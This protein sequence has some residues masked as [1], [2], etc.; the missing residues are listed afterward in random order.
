[1]VIAAGIV[2]LLL[3]VIAVLWWALKKDPPLPEH[4]R[5]GHVYVPMEEVQ[6]GEMDPSG[7]ERAAEQ[8]GREFGGKRGHLESFG[9]Y[10]D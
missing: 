6:P 5:A 8:L 7:E 4:P 3:L 1:M 2:F 9:K 10:G